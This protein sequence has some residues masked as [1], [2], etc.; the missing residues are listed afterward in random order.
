ME[1]INQVSAMCDN[2]WLILLM[3]LL[4]AVFLE[5]TAVRELVNFCR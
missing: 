3:N 2:E 1:K 4:L 5:I